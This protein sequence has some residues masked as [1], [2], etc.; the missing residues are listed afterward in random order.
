MRFFSK[1]MQSGSRRGF[2][3]IE[4][5]IVA[6]VVAIASAMAAP[7]LLNARRG[8]QLRSATTDLAS[9]LQR[10]RLVAVQQNRTIPILLAGGNTQVYVDSAGNASNGQYDLGEPMIQLPPNITITN[11][12]SPAFPAA[13]LG[14]AAPQAPPARFN[15]RGLP[16]AVVG[17]GCSN[18]VGGQIGYVYYLNQTINGV[19]RW[20]A[21][22]VTPGGQVKAWAYNGAVW[23]NY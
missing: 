4:L 7:V 13:T 22:A 16:C 9:L 6:S 11:I 2:S 10:G 14:F 19:T 5:V 20:S 8:Y 15:G 21:V 12:G 3:L 1:A 17:G 18:F 23:S